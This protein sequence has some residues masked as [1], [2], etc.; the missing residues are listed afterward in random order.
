MEQNH[1][2]T[3]VRIENVSLDTNP[4]DL[5]GEAVE[6]CILSENH[7]LCTYLNLFTLIISAL[8]KH[9]SWLPLLAMVKAALFDWKSN[10]RRNDSFIEIHLP[11]MLK[12]LGIQLLRQPLQIVVLVPAL[13]C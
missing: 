11:A 9:I 12:R 13:F 1:P 8:K 5:G 7:L 6:L 2:S 4:W 10:D 3:K